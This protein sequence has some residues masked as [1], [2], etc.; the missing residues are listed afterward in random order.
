MN[1]LTP[2]Q[3][4][5]KHQA[6]PVGGL[7]GL[8]FNEN[9]NGLSD[10]GAIVRVGRKVLI[11]EEKFFDWV[12]SCKHAKPKNTVQRQNGGRKSKSYDIEFNQNPSNLSEQD[13][14]NLI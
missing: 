4:S 5:K 2:K 7:R 8:I 12:K 3:F 9:I 6:F 13:L 10:T 14:I 1:Y 11:D